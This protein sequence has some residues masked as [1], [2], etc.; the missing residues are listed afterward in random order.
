MGAAFGTGISPSELDL[1][2]FSPDLVAQRGEKL[3][4]LIDKTENL[5]DSVSLGRSWQWGSCVC[6][7]QGA[8][9]WRQHLET[10]TGTQKHRDLQG[11]LPPPSRCF[12]AASLPVWRRS[13]SPLLPVPAKGDTFLS[14][15]LVPTVGKSHSLP[16]V[17]GEIK[18]QFTLPW[19][20]GLKAAGCK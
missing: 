8:G 6:A 12:P 4:L 15:P 1:C 13:S 14:S 9:R 11:I 10:L 7:P 5:V 3:E 16:A 20:P 19:Q 17:I 18:S 2:L